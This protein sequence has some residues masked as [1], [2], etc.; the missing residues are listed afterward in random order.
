MAEAPH[1]NQL[2]PQQETAIDLILTEK[3]DREVA[4]KFPTYRNR[5]TTEGRCQ[6]N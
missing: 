1:P 2:T 3:N 4:Q 5:Q 6:R